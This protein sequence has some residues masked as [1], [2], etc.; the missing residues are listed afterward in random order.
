[1][2]NV[3]HDFDLSRYIISKDRITEIY[4]KSSNL[5]D[6]NAKKAILDSASIKKSQFIVDEFLK[7]AL[8]NLET[9][10][11]SNHKSSLIDL[12]HTVHERKK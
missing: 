4:A 8:L 2:S 7:K 1:M 12:I 3:I 6:Q 10:P 11:S 5:L 9:I